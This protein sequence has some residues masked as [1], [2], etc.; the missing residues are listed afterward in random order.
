MP[1]HQAGGNDVADV[2]NLGKKYKNRRNKNLKKERKRKKRK[3]CSH[4]TCSWMNGNSPCLVVCSNEKFPWT[5]GR[6]DEKRG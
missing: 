1:L 2:H 6:S 3:F 4:N 5:H